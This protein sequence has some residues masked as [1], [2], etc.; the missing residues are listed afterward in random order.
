MAEQRASEDTVLTEDPNEVT[1][2]PLRPVAAVNDAEPFLREADAAMNFGGIRSSTVMDVGCGTG[3]S[4]YA[5]AALFPNINHVIG[6]DI[7]EWCLTIARQNCPPKSG[8]CD[9]FQF[10]KGNIETGEGLFQ[11]RGIRHIVSIHCFSCLKRQKKAFETVHTLLCPGGGAA[12]LFAVQMD[13]Y[14]LLGDLLDHPKWGQYMKD[15][16]DIIPESHE[17]QY[18]ENYYRKLLTEIGFEIHTCRTEETFSSY[19]NA[20]W[21]LASLPFRQSLPPSLLS[22]FR[23]ELPMLLKRHAVVNDKMACRMYYKIM[24]IIVFK[25]EELDVKSQ[26]SPLDSQQTSDNK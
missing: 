17:K 1:T 12:F 8:N 13:Y 3:N 14:D 15:K 5:L 9:I 11:F 18:D 24:K 26:G 19:P 10:I 2:C 21:V 7:E 22:E 6:V 20:E 23:E 4:S 25:R 16:E